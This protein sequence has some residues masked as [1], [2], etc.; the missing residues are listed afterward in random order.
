MTVTL[1]DVQCTFLI[2]SPSV[3]LRMR[4]VSEKKC[5]TENQNIY[6]MFSNLFSEAGPFMRYVEKYYRELDRSQMT[7]GRMRIACWIPKAA[8]IQWECVILIAFPRQ[9]CLR[10]GASMLL[11]T[12]IVCLFGAWRRQ[13]LS[14]TD[15]HGLRTKGVSYFFLRS[16]YILHKAF[17]L[18]RTTIT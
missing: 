8:D 1:H 2:I 13:D 9:Q 5:C 12:Y 14:L 18:L 15:R 4:N 7:I 3:L 17:S 11:C 10:E 16:S 6:F